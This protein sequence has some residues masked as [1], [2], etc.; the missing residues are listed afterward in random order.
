MSK[1]IPIAQLDR[2]IRDYDL[3]EV[4]H[5]NNLIG[6]YTNK[7]IHIYTTTGEYV[8]RVS[9]PSRTEEEVV[10]ETDVLRGL[11]QTLAGDFVVHVIETPNGSPFIIRDGQIHTIFRF[12]KG[13]DFYNRWNSHNPDQHFIESLGKKS[14]TLHRSLSG[15]DVPRTT[16]KSLPA[17][18]RKYHSDLASLGLNMEPYRVLIDQAEGTSLVHTDLRIR[19]FVVNASEISTIV[20]FDDATYGNQLYD[21]AWTIK[22]CFGLQPSPMINIEAAKSFL[23]WYQSN[24]EGKVSTGDIVKIMTL[25]CIR[26]LHFLFFSASGSISRERIDQLTSINLAQLDLF[27]KG[28]AVASAI[29]PE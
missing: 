21:I 8:L 29:T 4:V 24:F 1:E 7:N 9:N 6:G 3:G 19:N 28:D 16:R 13:E 12:A 20:D 27:S 2:T 22:E 10:F 26:T 18:L 25:A 14:A 23:K 11:K 15:I 17:K 5:A